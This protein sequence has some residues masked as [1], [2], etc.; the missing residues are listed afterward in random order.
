MNVASKVDGIQWLGDMDVLW[1]QPGGIWSTEQF[2]KFGRK[3]VHN[4]TFQTVI[5]SVSEEADGQI[6]AHLSTSFPSRLPTWGDLRKAKDMFLGEDKRAIQVFVPT[7]EWV[8]IHPYCLHLFACLSADVLPDFRRVDD[9][10]RVG[11]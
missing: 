5:V 6:W 4:L 7:S 10:G 9:S 1:P 2:D 11:I 8:N 3:Y